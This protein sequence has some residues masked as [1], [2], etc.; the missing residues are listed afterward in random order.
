MQLRITVEGA[1]KE[2]VRRGLNAALAVFDKANMHPLTAAEGRFALE[3]WDI[4]GFPEDGFSDEESAAASVW[5]EAEQAA[6]DACCANWPGDR[7]RPSE[8]LELVRK[9]DDV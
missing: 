5:M 7:E 1:T 4:Q 2:E 8:V 3:G 9:A 6:I